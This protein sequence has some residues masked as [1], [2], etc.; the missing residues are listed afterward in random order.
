MSGP[1]TF[2]GL[3]IA[4]RGMQAGRSAMDV[5]GHNLANVDTPGYS[6][7]ETV[8]MTTDPYALMV[9][10]Q[11]GTPEHMG[12][13]VMAE[14]IRRVRDEFL[15]D[16]IRNIFSTT[17]QWESMDAVLRKVE[18]LFPEPGENGMQGI[19]GEFFNN[20][21]ELNSSPQARG[22]RSAVREAAG[23]LTHAFRQTY[24]QVENE[25]S[26]TLGRIEEKVNRVN[27][28]ATE[29]AYLNDTIVSAISLGKQPND[30]MDKR[31]VLLDELA[32]IADIRVE[33]DAS[34]QVAV[35]V[36]GNY[37]VNGDNEV[38][39]FD[40][41]PVNDGALAGLEAAI[42]KIEDLQAQLDELAEAFIEVVNGWHEKDGFPA[43]FTGSGAA[44]F[45]LSDEIKSNLNNINSYQALNIAGMRTELTMSGG[46]AT[47]ENFYAGMVTGLGADV[48]ST[49]GM[50]DSQKLIREQNENMRQSVMG[51]STDEELTRM[52]QFQYAFQAS[53]RVVTV[54]DEMLDTLI[55]RMI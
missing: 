15:D 39:A 46:T 4:R 7:Q 16:S 55:N 50:L 31:D 48:Q 28:I 42:E 18:V 8:Q 51:V 9:F 43:F 1:G 33:K 53:A 19:I 5:T 47:F 26:I 10:N 36:S 14:K 37:I 32:T 30:L 54:M 45:E 21:H 17:A 38:D 22:V 23:N 34:G 3:E 2:F 35:M 6:R 52:I 27:A 40:G 41:P 12:T 24:Q 44:D 20:W 25:K 13:G 49:K 29:V 11:K